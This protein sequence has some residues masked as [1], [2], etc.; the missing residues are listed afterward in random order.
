VL[1][2][3]QQVTQARAGNPPTE[4]EN[5]QGHLYGTGRACVKLQVLAAIDRAENVWC[6][7][8][9]ETSAEALIEELRAITKRRPPVHGGGN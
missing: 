6:T 1:S 9:V 5:T 7:R 8:A 3:A 2:L 4:E